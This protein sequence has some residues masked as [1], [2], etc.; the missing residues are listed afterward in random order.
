MSENNYINSDNIKTMEEE[1]T[2]KI[3]DSTTNNEKNMKNS[4]NINAQN[5]YRKSVDKGKNLGTFILGKK[6][7]EGTFGIVRVGTHILTG[8]KV[9]VKILD[10][11]KI[12]KSSDKKRLE[13]EIKI[14]KVMHHNNIVHLYNVILTSQSI[15]LVMEYIEGK[16]LFE[17]IIHKRRLSELESCKFYQQLISCIEYLGKLKIAHRDLKPENL[18][19]DKR[20]NIKLV[21]FGLS[22]IYK[23]NELLS[24]P[25]GSP[26]YAAPEMLSGGKYNGLNTDIWSS[27]II[28]YTMMCGCLPFD[29]PNNDILYD[30]IK[31]GIFKIPEFISEPAKD[32]L[33]RILNIDPSKRYTI[34]QIK[35]HPWFNLINQ[36]IYMNEGLLINTHIVPIDEEIINK[37]STE[38]EYNGIEVKINL[39]ANKH[40]HLTTT[41]YLLLKKKINKGGKLI[42]NMSS[43]EFKKY[44]NNKD[45]L[46]SNYH[47]NWKLLLKERAGY[48]SIKEE[49]TKD[50]DNNE[51]NINREQFIIIENINKQDNDKINNG[52]NN[53]DYNTFNNININSSLYDKIKPHENKINKESTINKNNDDN[54]T[55]N[56]NDDDNDSIKNEEENISK[57]KKPTIFEYLKKIKEIQK[58]NY[59]K[60]ENK[61]NEKNYKTNEGTP[62]KEQNIENDNIFQTEKKNKKN[63]IMKEYENKININHK[64]NNIDSISALNQNRKGKIYNNEKNAYF[65]FKHY[66]NVKKKGN[67]IN[68][69]INLNNILS[70]TKNIT[71]DANTFNK[72]YSK[73]KDKKSNVEDLINN[74]TNQFSIK[75]ETPPQSNNSPKNKHKKFIKHKYVESRYFNSKSSI[76]PK[77]EEYLNNSFKNINIFENS[78]IIINKRKNNLNNK[79]IKTNYSQN[80]SV[81]SSLNKRKK[82]SQSVKT[83]NK[84]VKKIKNSNKSTLVASDEAKSIYEINKHKDKDNTNS[85]KDINM[86]SM[87]YSKK[88]RNKEV[89]ESFT[90]NYIIQKKKKKGLFDLKNNKR[91]KYFN[92]N[93][94]VEKTDYDLRNNETYSKYNLYKKNKIK[95]ELK[96]QIN[97]TY[98]S[99]NKTQKDKEIKYKNIE[100]QK[101]LKIINKNND[102]IKMSQNSSKIKKICTINNT[103]NNS[104]IRIRNNKK[105][106]IIINKS[107]SIEKYVNKNKKPNY[108]KKRIIN[109][110]KLNK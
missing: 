95:E 43:S 51:N 87:N 91:K 59:F 7:G 36:K 92:S 86:N 27:G 28:L 73:E 72:I 56:K 14:L 26:S 68:N 107:K 37:M 69:K 90:L 93:I 21:D 70:E 31:K 33:H 54:D 104:K 62:K 57:K 79:T 89:N 66:L 74:N 80:K 100:R 106:K 76:D 40:N 25:C 35:A 11:Q 58:K 99:S 96:N 48:K 32:I 9:A 38:Y 110:S 88:S 10:K 109:M 34:E 101:N 78:N 46:I 84:N 75:H 5:Q 23:N 53:V 71:F 16:E 19:L 98:I 6:I 30:K 1:A 61:I 52:I 4:E 65:D 105:S 64:S 83:K 44:I 85:Y 17:Y 63:K 49:N 45:N 29:D 2:Q 55:I 15:Y 22:I 20:K 24:T 102:N 39:L 82:Y 103:K 108:I 94:S 41:Y 97:R 8:E 60:E 3:N 50:K 77:L 12:S 47:G 81:D 42:G 67:T 13:R 18:L